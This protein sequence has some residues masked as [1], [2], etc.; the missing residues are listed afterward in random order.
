MSGL[1]FFAVSGGSRLA[2]VLFVAL[3]VVMFTL[4]VPSSAGAAAT[5][6]Q[7][8][9]AALAPH[10]PIDIEGNAGFTAAN[11]VVSGTGTA[12]DPYLIAGWSIGSA[13]PLGIQIRNTDAHALL[14]DL[15]VTATSAAALYLYN[16]ANVTLDNVTASVNNG[17]GIRFE[18]SR[19]ILVDRSQLIGNRIGLVILNSADAVVRNSTFA[20]NVG[21]G[22]V[23]SGSPNV[24]LVANRFS[25]N[26]FGGGAHG[27]DLAFTTDDVVVGNQFVANGIYLDGDALAYFDSHTISADNLIGG[28]P[29]LYERDC[30]GLGLTGMDLGELLLV[31]CFHARISNLTAGGGDVGLLIAFANDAIVGPGVVISDASLGIE[32]TQSVNVQI[33]NASV[34]DTA[35]GIQVDASAGIRISGTEASAPFS[36]AGPYDGLSIRSSDLVNASQNIL[37]HRRNAIAVVDSGNVTLSN[38]VAAL[39]VMG[40]NASTSRDL[41]VTGNRFAQDTRGM[42]L[43]NLTNGTFRGNTFLAI[44]AQTVNV[45]GSSG[46]HF[47]GNGFASAQT[48]AYDG[49]GP[50]DSW[51]GGYPAGGNY[52][53]D[54]HG[55]D[56]M[57]GPGQ[58]LSGPDGFGDTP[59][60]FDMNATDH[61]PRMVAPVTSDLPPDA[62]LLVAPAVGTVLTSFRVTANLSS[63]FEDPLA[64]LL[65]RWSWDA[66]ATWTPWMVGKSALHRFDSTGVKT[67]VLQ[68]RDTAGLTDT[69][70]AE[71]RV[72]PK[73]DRLPPA[74]LFNPPTAVEVGRPIPVVVNI[75]DDSGIANA[76]LL[77][78]GV[79]GGA[80]HA[81]TLQIENNRANFTTTIPAQPRAGMVEVVIYANDTWANVARAP[82][83]APNTIQVVDTTTPLYLGLTLAAGLVIAVAVVAVILWRRRQRRVSEPPRDGP[84][85]PP[86]NP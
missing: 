58:N 35:T 63:D 31:G 42:R 46:L 28:L 64:A 17:D 24:T 47:T 40:L 41:V 61:Y 65:V 8:V 14:R 79:D 81:L 60:G 18:S 69:W 73:P 12:G 43:V 32:V 75:T 56:Q 23:L 54:Y 27:I 3:V 76:T 25:Y 53:G 19:S 6:P 72:D 11:G 4:V 78:R 1:I 68:V 55:L 52:W 38:N 49:Q 45:S 80:F 21:D 22:A 20:V 84:A 77:Y 9:G 57:H 70:S 26:G 16:V 85:R 2:R 39:S 71:V 34:L 59:Y 62:L 48:L 83:G 30:N 37:R 66:G 44:L 15:E 51:D 5:P 86:G 13:S 29:V 50:S 67:I 82:V 36:A 10:L 33:L 74:I 7:I